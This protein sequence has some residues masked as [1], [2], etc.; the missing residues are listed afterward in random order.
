MMERLGRW[1]LRVAQH[2]TQRRATRLKVAVA[3]AMAD[4]MRL[5]HRSLDQWQPLNRR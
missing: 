3:R 2:R 5:C 4:E 1:L